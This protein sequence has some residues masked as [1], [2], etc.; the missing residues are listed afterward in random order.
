MRGGRG[1]KIKDLTFY[2]LAAGRK[3]EKKLC[4]EA[5]RVCKKHCLK[6]HQILLEVK[7]SEFSKLREQTPFHKYL[8]YVDGPG[9]RIVKDKMVIEK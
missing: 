1:E 9:N 2:I 7:E 4:Y 6:P 8:K 5:S 3:K